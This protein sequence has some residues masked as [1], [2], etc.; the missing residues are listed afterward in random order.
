VHRYA[1]DAEREQQQPNEW[2]GNQRHERKGPA[3]DEEDAPEQ[4]C[5]HDRDPRLSLDYCTFSVRKKFHV[6]DGQKRVCA[7]PMGP[8]VLSPV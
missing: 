8:V 6:G 1:H 3:E 2:I 5:E 4:E 7:V